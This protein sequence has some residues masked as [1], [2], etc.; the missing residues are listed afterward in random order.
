MD[1]VSSD[2]CIIDDE[3]KLDDE[4][5]LDDYR[6]I[7]HE[8]ILLAERGTTVDYAFLCKKES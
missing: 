1:V 8:C 6:K 4:R 7:I 2:E 5:K 3:C